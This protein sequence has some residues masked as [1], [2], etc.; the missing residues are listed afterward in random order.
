MSPK[1][2]GNRERSQ[3]EAS[4]GPNPSPARQA[5]PTTDA[6]YD[7]DDECTFKPKIKPLPSHYGRGK[8]QDG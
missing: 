6:R 5:R 2:G 3:S 8:E 4:G 7:E 1:P